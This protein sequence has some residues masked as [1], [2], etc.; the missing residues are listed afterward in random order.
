MSEFL[1]IGQVCKIMESIE[2]DQPFTVVFEKKDGS[3]RTMLCMRNR[4]QAVILPKQAAP[5]DQLKVWDRE[6]KSPRQFTL[7]KVVSISIP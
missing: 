3:I 1:G 6:A 4:D 2:N 5:D 7:S